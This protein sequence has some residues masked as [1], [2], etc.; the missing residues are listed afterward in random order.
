MTDPSHLRTIKTKPKPPPL[1]EDTFTADWLDEQVFPELEWAVDGII[2]EGLTFLV[3]PPKAGKSWLILN[4]A[5]SVAKNEPALGCIEPSTK[6]PRP[7]FYL[8]LEDGQ[9]RL[10]RRLRT[11]APNQR[12]PPNLTFK[13]RCKPNQLQDTISTYLYQ[14]YIQGE[15]APLVILD[16]LGKVMPSGSSTESSYERDYR[17]SSSLKQ[18]ADD[19]PGTAFV[20]I[21]H[22]RKAES[23]DFVDDVSGTHGL[24]GGA[25]TIVILKRPR[26]SNE[27]TLLIT[28]R[29][30][31]EK[32]YSIITNDPGVW[33]L[34][35]DTV[36]EST[37]KAH[38][39]QIQNNLGDNSKEMIDWIAHHGQIT[40]SEFEQKFGPNTRRYLSRFAK[41]EK[42]I[43]VRRGVY[44]P[45]IPSRIDS[46]GA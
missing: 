11:V 45:I 16:T 17:I 34:N 42:I 26:H 8:A 3:G 9:R 27:A 23:D 2:P 7:V 43:Q 12:M 21:H 18:M 39:Q 24:T 44:E 22:D 14:N 28:G 15:P 30:V 32:P 38:T 4:L 40:N 25:D 29:D 13:I 33:V 6:T 46:P 5:L 19:Y 1:L 10:Q 35:A 20:V 31:E 37:I 36:E 41:A